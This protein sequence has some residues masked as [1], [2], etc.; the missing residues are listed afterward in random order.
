M[1]IIAGLA[2]T[3][4]AVL[5]SVPASAD[6]AWYRVGDSI[7]EGV[8]GAVITG[9]SGGTVDA[10]VVR[11]NKEP[12]QNRLAAVHLVDG[13]GAKLTPLRW[14]GA[15]PV[16]LESID[17]VPGKPGEYIALASAGTGYAFT[18]A[19]GTAT[20][21]KTFELP[22][23]K[24]KANYESFALAER[25]GG[26]VAVWADRGKAEK[27]PGRLF[28]APFDTAKFTFGKVD[29]A[30]IRVPYP[31]EHVRHISDVKILP[32]GGLLISSASDNG[33]DGPF[34]SAVYRVGTVSAKAR[35]STGK[36][37]SRGRFTGHKIEGI[38]CLPGSAQGL[39]GTDDEN[40]GGYVRLAGVCT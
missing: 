3:A 15:E 39:L 30:D 31:E 38:A 35:L 34:D 18:L 29:E 28:A 16:D 9:A 2:L 7:T 11:D 19:G 4:A 26:T 40:L 22:E 8:S 25:D 36:P 32:G 10:L 1:K 17:A 23:A 13:E 14:S 37:E 27:R 24:G 5:T 20:V 21:R 33:D 6:S 12:G